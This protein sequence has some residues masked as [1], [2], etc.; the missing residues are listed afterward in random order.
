MAF[1]VLPVPNPGSATFNVDAQLFAAGLADFAEEANALG[2]VIDL[3]LKST[4]T[5]SLTIG[6]GSKTLTV[7]TGLGYVIGHPVR[8]ASVAS[9]A[10]FMDG[11]VTAYNT[12]TGSLTV[13]VASVGGSGTI[14][15]W[16][17]MVLPGGGNFASLS[18]NKFTGRQV[19]ADEVTL[20]SASTVDF[21]TGNSNQ[22][23]ITGTTTITAV[24]M[25]QGA[26][27]KAR[28]SGACQ[29]THGSN[30]QIQG[31]AN[32]TTTAG[33]ILTFT[34]NGTTVRVEISKVNGS[35]VFAPTV[36]TETSDPSYADD[37]SNPASTDWVNGKALIT[38]TAT[39]TL[40]GSASYDIFSAIPTGVKRVTLELIS[41][42]TTGTSGV[43]AL[44][45]DT[46]IIST[47]YA[48]VASNITSTTSHSVTQLSTGIDFLN[49]PAATNISTGILTFNNIP[50]NNWIF[51]GQMGVENATRYMAV[52]GNIALTSALKTVRVKTGNG[53]DTFDGGTAVLTWEY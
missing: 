46:G 9:P 4:S 27:I 8:I 36:I 14:A 34:S 48:G 19:L 12:G 47:G 13:E 31:G 38:R 44:V 2:S 17:T 26:V 20:S 5:T 43:Q 29:L 37:T 40:S 1:P 24:T 39:V 18:N 22:F 50:G 28:F 42:S 52:I 33:D 23:L 6:T 41:I 49:I 30:L 25:A 11:I 15:I 16:N 7:Q 32:Y 21:T 45:G 51:S 10:N 53:T 3:S 35:A